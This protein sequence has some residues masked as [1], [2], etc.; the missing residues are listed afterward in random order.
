MLKELHELKLKLQSTGK[1]YLLLDID[2]T[3]SHTKKMYFETLMRD[4]SNPEN[5]T[6]DEMIARYNLTNFV[7]YWAD[8][9]SFEI[10]NRLMAN[11]E[12]HADLELREGALESINKIN[13]KLAIAGYLSAR[14]EV[15]HQ[16]T[17]DWIQRKG[18]PEAE[19]ILR[20]NYVNDSNAWKAA[21]LEFLWPEV[22][23]IVDDNQGLVDKL[24][25][26]YQGVLFVYNYAGQNDR[27]GFNIVHCADWE[28]V[29]EKV[30]N[31]SPAK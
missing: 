22:I 6:V 25:R 9:K 3:I 13:E 20:P 16:T 4:H 23:G 10:H 19:V 30:T 15:I 2:D 28:S 31:Y 29:V 27:E 26:G 14:P 5:L 17:K 8:E 24:H 11:A 7:S 21:V 1:K 18:L 12:A